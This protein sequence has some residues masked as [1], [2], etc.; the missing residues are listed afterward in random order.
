M[1][2]G[3]QE[4]YEEKIIDSQKDEIWLET[5]K[6]PIL[7]ESGEVIG[8]VGIARDI[9]TR[10]KGE[11]ALRES[12][13]RLSKINECFINFT[14][15]S[16]ENINRLTS[17]CGELFGATCALYNRLDQGLLYSWGQWNTPSDYN[18]VDKPDGHICYDVIKS[19]SDEVLVVSN[20]QETHYAQTDPNV[21]PF[22]LQTYVGKAVMFF[23]TYIG[24]LC[25]VFQYDFVPSEADKK[26]MGIIASAIGVEEER[27]RAEEA[28]RESEERYQN[29]YNN[30][31]DMYFT[32]SLNGIVKSVNQFGA[33]YLGYSKEELIGGP[34][35]TIVYKDDL[36]S[37]QKQVAEIFNQKLQKSE[38]EFRKIRKDGSI[39]WVHER[40]NLVLDENDNPIELW[41]ICRD[42]TKPK[43]AEEALQRA[44]DELE[45]RVEERTAELS[46][47]NE[48]LK[49]KTINLKE[50]NTALKVLLNKRQEDKEELEEKVLSNVKELIF[51]YIKNLKMSRL[52]DRQMG[53][54]GI[55]ESNL[56]EIITPFL[57][58]LSSKYS[59]LTPKEIQVAGLVKEGKTSKEIAE[60][61]DSSKN[62]VEF[63]R[64]NLRK[65]LGIRN[66]KTN[67]NSYLLSLP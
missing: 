12:E 28:L 2:G 41:I 52:D 15:N 50:A 63:H 49:N 30:A 3:K 25:V 48:E 23:D 26:L 62:A 66:T 33:D 47:V 34:V 67:L 45:K 20:L 6:S 57:R 46:K 55:I 56:N 1:G 64:R 18:P 27:K 39:L 16:L 10:K 11:E 32:V 60:L 36:G 42:V 31:P 21:V 54:L 37:V 65:K 35:W 19:A 14:P 51:P 44:H 58:K 8:T 29:L 43:K 24:S 38:L 53:L 7:D 13:E 40:T 22:S 4:V 59:N 61:L 9:T 17:L 5:I